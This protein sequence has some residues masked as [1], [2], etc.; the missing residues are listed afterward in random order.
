MANAVYASST[1][2]QAFDV[3]T[4][5]HVTLSCNLKYLRKLHEGLLIWLKSV[6]L[7]D[8]EDRPSCSFDPTAESRNRVAA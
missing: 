3:Y 6:L 7:L 5:R 2:V 1:S 8:S 4:Q